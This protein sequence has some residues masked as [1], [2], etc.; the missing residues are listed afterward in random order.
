MTRKTFDD[1]KNLVEKQIASGLSVP[2]FCN[3][4]NLNHKYFYSRK[5]MIVNASDNAGFIQAQ[6]ITK[7]TTLLETKPEPSITFASPAGELT[8][9]RDTSAQFIVEQ[10]MQL[11]ALDGRVYV[12]CNKGRDKLKVLYWDKTGFALWRKISS[13]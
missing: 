8:L 10:Q 5:S 13:L 1:W 6:V 9:P 3:Q 11:S 2:L 4:H 12:F 7:Q